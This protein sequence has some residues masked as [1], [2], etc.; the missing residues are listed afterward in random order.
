[1]VLSLVA[2]FVNL[3]PGLG[4]LRWFDGF[5]GSALPH[6]EEAAA[7]GLTETGSALAAS[8]VFAMGLGLA[9]LF[10]LRRRDWAQAAVSVPFVRRLHQWWQMGFGF[11]WLYDRLF[12]RPV[13]WLASVNRRDF[14]D[15]IYDGAARASA[16]F[17]HALSATENG[18][19]RAYA[20]GIVG[21]AIFFL[22]LTLLL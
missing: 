20:A 13:V 14:V 15:S 10:F 8:A 6:T 21:G 16:A 12:V 9:W 17:Y 5:M 4:N 18:L 2:G 1:M 19:V 22:A 7:G 11:D 3:P